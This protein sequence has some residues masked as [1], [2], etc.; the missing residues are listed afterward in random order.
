MILRKSVSMRMALQSDIKEADS[1]NLKK[2]QENWQKWCK[3]C[4]RIVQIWNEFSKNS[5]ILI[6]ISNISFLNWIMTLQ[7][8]FLNWI[9]CV[10]KIWFTR[11]SFLI[12]ISFLFSS[13]LNQILTVCHYP[14]S[15]AYWGYFRQ[16]LTRLVQNLTLC[17]DCNLIPSAHGT[18]WVCPLKVI[19]GQFTSL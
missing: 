6:K 10:V 15:S 11:K 5:L 7:N 19:I 1:V 12:R 13:F 9:T 17:Y 3:S 8:S 16:I 4:P 2:N 18:Q 14:R